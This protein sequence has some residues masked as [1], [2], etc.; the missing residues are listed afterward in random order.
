[1]YDGI[2]CK[3]EV[4]F[5]SRVDP[6]VCRQ[7]HTVGLGKCL[8]HIHWALAVELVRTGKPS[9]HDKKLLAGQKSLSV[10]VRGMVYMM[11]TLELT[12]AT[13]N[14]RIGR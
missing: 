8:A 1:M 4:A 5:V 12:T 9:T 3:L 6:Y 11:L 14:N 10:D 2:L 7:L 13:D